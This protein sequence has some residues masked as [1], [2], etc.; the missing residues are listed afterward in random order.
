MKTITG[1]KEPWGISVSDDE[2]IMVVEHS[3]HCVTLVNKEGKKVRSFGKR[4]FDTF[5]TKGTKVDQFTNP[6]GVAITNDNHILVTDDHQLQK[7]TFDGVC[8]QS[9]G[10]TETGSGQLQFN[11]PAGIA[12]HPTTGL[13]FVADSGNNRI[14]VFY[15]DLTY[16]TFYH[17]TW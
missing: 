16:G 17:S 1:F 2:D 4:V 11:D 7:L 12:V 3:G 13:V 9:V 8:L 10:S 15:S 5:S 14:Q 6:R